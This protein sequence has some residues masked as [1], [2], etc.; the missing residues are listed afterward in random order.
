M[1][2]YYAVQNLSVCT[3]TAKTQ[4]LETRPYH[5][6]PMETALDSMHASASG[7]LT[8]AP[9]LSLCPNARQPAENS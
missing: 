7:K 8:S 6:A 9:T 2:A 1:I 4:T 5:R 3:L